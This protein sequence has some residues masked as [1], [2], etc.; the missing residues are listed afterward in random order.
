MLD[1][2]SNG[3]SM[4]VTTT[5]SNCNNRRLG[6]KG[7][8]NCYHSWTTP[9]VFNHWDT[10]TSHG[11][12]PRFYN[13]WQLLLAVTSGILITR[14]LTV[15]YCGAIMAGHSCWLLPVGFR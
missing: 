7:F 10:D 11:C 15:G 8:A 12:L 2:T 3:I 9:A 14:H 1:A 6:N 5:W 4:P 13:S